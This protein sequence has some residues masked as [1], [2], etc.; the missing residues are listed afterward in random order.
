MYAQ[1]TSAPTVPMVFVDSRDEHNVS[2]F[3]YVFVIHFFAVR[4][5]LSGFLVSFFANVIC[6]RDNV[7]AE[8]LTAFNLRCSDI[9]SFKN[10]KILF[11]MI[12]KYSTFNP[13]F[14]YIS[15]GL[16]NPERILG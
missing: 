7:L 9:C 11:P 16:S 14:S 4:L 12:E 10:G 15:A 8:T 5:I 6:V 2:L 1:R 13:G 3:R